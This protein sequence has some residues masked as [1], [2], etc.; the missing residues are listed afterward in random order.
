[1]LRAVLRCV[2][3]EQGQWGE[4]EVCEDVQS[5]QSHPELQILGS[6]FLLAGDSWASGLF[7]LLSLCLLLPAAARGAALGRLSQEP[8]WYPRRLG[9]PCSRSGCWRP[10]VLIHPDP[11]WAMCLPRA[12]ATLGAQQ[13]GLQDKESPITPSFQ[14]PRIHP[15]QLCSSHVWHRQ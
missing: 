9:S 15:S 3:Y 7:D 2:T 10:A 14:Q 5:S 8:L 11:K 13:N 1:M 4:D 6:C 12:A